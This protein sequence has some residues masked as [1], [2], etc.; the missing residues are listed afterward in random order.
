MDSLSFQDHQH[1]EAMRKSSDQ[2]RQAILDAR[3]G[4]CPATPLF[5]KRLPKDYSNATGPKPDTRE[6]WDR[7]RRPTNERVREMMERK[8]SAGEIA[9]ALKISVQKASAIMQAIRKRRE[10]SQLEVDLKAKL[11]G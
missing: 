9:A 2:L 4:V 3:N 7:S 8:K 6:G 11:W 5:P 1:R 10:P